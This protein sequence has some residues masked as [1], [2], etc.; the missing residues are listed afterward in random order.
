ME[1]HAHFFL[2]LCPLR[3]LPERMNTSLFLHLNI[4]S[5]CI[6]HPVVESQD[7]G[8]FFIFNGGVG[9]LSRFFSREKKHGG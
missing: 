8:R 2:Y 5:R 7:V 6:Y 3:F 4:C 1:V 9:E